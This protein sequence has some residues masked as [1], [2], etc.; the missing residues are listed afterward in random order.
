MFAEVVGLDVVKFGDGAELD[1]DCGT[2]M[3]DAGVTGGSGNV[4]AG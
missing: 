2:E 4:V 1:I 3:T